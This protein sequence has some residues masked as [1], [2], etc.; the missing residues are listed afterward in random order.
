MSSERTERS[1]KVARQAATSGFMKIQKKYGVEGT[2]ITG[3]NY[4]KNNQLF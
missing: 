3:Q 1:K 2:P 4:R